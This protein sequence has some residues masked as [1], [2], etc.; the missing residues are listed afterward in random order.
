MDRKAMIEGLVPRAEGDP[1]LT[2]RVA[3]L[4]RAD[5]QETRAAG[6]AMRILDPGAEAGPALLAEARRFVACTVPHWHFGLVRDRARNKAYEAALRAAIRPGMHV[7][8]IGTGTGLLAMMA[9]RAGAAHIV[10]CESNPAVAEAARQVIAA[11]GFGD[12]ISVI[13][14]LSTALELGIDLEAPADLLVS[15]IVSHDLLR[16]QV[17]P[18]HED[19]VA[20]LLAP[21]APVIP[22]RGEI[23][24]ALADLPSARF[25]CEPVEGFDLSAFDPLLPPE[26]RLRSDDRD[27]V[28]RSGGETLFTFDFA[29]AEPVAGAAATVACTA[30][31]GCATGILQWIA[32]DLAPGVRHE[33][34][35]AP[36]IPRSNWRLRYF[37]FAEPAETRAG[38]RIVVCGV[39]DRHRVDIWRA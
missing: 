24:V 2:L 30:T 11:N 10:T 9:A 8:E 25:G 3:Q 12:R 35:P 37:E 33:N 6:M 28:L 19:A 27:I 32:L 36:G 29:T 13:A 15:E 4:M 7:L 22:G 34:G 23:R 38:E 20:R 31:G 1:A 26:R 39:H 14:K 18:A 16:E 21:G 5:G 17:L